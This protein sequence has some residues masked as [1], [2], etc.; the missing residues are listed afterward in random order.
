MVSEVC[1]AP[2][3]ADHLQRFYAEDGPD[4]YRADGW[5]LSWRK[6][7]SLLCHLAVAAPRRPWRAREPDAPPPG[8][9]NLY[10]SGA[11]AD[12]VMPRAALADAVS[13]RLGHVYRSGFTLNFLFS[14]LAVMAG[15]GAVFAWQDPAIKAACVAA[16]LGFIALIVL[17]T[18]RGGA[19][20]A[21]HERWL[22]TRRLAEMLRQS[23][24]LA[25]VGAA[26]TMPPRAELPW[27]AWYA[28]AT[29]RETGLPP[30]IADPAWLQS[31][32]DHAIAH[33]IDGQIAYHRSAKVRSLGIHH[34]LDR[35]GIWLFGITVAFG[36]AYLAAFSLVSAAHVHDGFWYGAFKEMLKP[37]VTFV[38]AGF[39]A[40]GAALY[41]I[42]A[43]ADL[44]TT[45]ARSAATARALS[46]IRNRMLAERENPEFAAVRALL[47][48]AAETML[49]DLNDWRH[50]H[51][52]RPLVIPA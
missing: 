25:L 19:V 31:V 9:P 32:L 20:R 21:W 3:N 36:L 46:D 6:A 27:T 1:S 23:R 37:A 11:I 44:E 10:E 35:I 16:E 15:L 50:I 45:A 26:N 7:W 34:G 14:A 33:T 42:R 48:E 29:L 22:E 2:A 4:G 5:F 24:D 28:R 43:Q 30:A 12:I 17:I 13:T 40:L 47:A 49:G 18:Q 39:P 8:A 41:G 52:H 38:S 51:K